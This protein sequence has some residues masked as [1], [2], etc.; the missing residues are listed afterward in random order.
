M[1]LIQ[2]INAFFLTIQGNIFISVIA[3]SLLG[4]F[5]FLSHGY[6]LNAFLRNRNMIAMSL[7]LPPIAMI[8]TTTIATNFFLSLGMIGALSIIRYRTPVKSGYELALLFCLI[9]IGVV[10]GV[11]LRDAVGLAVFIALLAPLI[12]LATR[13]FPS[14]VRSE[15]PQRTDHVDVIVRLDGIFEKIDE[16][17]PYNKYLRSYNETVFNGKPSTV[18]SLVFDSMDAALSF[19]SACQNIEKISELNINS[20]SV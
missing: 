13:Y 10:G 17:D 6:T 11:N 18:L 15:I 12:Y 1:S 19:K 8:I 20:S 4:V 5:V 9:T 16:L 7:M 3:V 2:S 14:V